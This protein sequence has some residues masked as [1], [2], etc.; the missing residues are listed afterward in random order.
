MKE[1]I[2]IVSSENEYYR[3]SNNYKSSYDEIDAGYGQVVTVDYVNETKWAEKYRPK[4]LNDLILPKSV[5]MKFKDMV[6]KKEIKDTILFSS[7]GGTGKDSIVQVLKNEIGFDMLAIN[8]SKDRSIDTIRTKVVGFSSTLNMYG[9]KKVVNLGETGGMNK[10]SIDSLK[11]VLEEFSTNVNWLFTTNDLSNI[12]EALMTRFGEPLDLSVIPVEEKGELAQKLF[13][14]LKTILDYE[15]IEY[16]DNDV[17]F[18]IGKY[19]PSYRKLM[20]VL[21]SSIVDGRLQPQT[22][23]DE[24]SATRVLGLINSKSYEELVKISESVDI[25]SF[26]NYTNSNFSTMIEASKIPDFLDLFNNL[27]VAVGE[28]RMFL[29]I[30]FLVF[31]NGCIQ[32]SVSFKVQ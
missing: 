5:L 9:T 28:R 12:P 8:A 26:M 10:I 21:E 17:A 25:V 19:F 20:V 22:K 15:S 32:K 31:C 23:V 13:F 27:Q 29:N 16:D 11:G 1:N 14:R 2:K 24:A 30:S 6:K 18:L 3:A 7:N 4:K